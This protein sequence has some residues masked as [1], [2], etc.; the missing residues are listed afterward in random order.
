[1]KLLITSL[2]FLLCCFGFCQTESSKGVGINTYDLAP[3]SALQIDSK[4]RGMVQPR[5]TT[6][7]MNAIPSPL[8]GAFVFN[9][10]NNSWYIRKNGT[11]QTFVRT[12]TP[13][14]ILNRGQT[15]GGVILRTDD[16]ITPFPVNKDNALSAGTGFYE[17][18][19]TNGE[20]KIV[21]SGTYLISAGFSTTSLPSGN[22]NYYIEVSINGANPIIIT[23]GAVNLPSSDYWGTSG[24][25]LLLLSANDVINVGYL[26]KGA[27]SGSIQAAFFNIGISKL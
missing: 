12:E 9:T 14:V 17:L 24:N 7:Q 22:R 23:D 10:T 18:S 13:S 21:K 2:F 4:T 8:D 16:I 5:M 26:L 19:A 6:T 3:G 25:T 27:S 1:M 20:V 15:S 11:W